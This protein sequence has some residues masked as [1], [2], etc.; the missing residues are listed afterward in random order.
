MF[1]QFEPWRKKRIGIVGYGISGQSAERLLQLLEYSSQPIPIWDEN[2]QLRRPS[3]GAN[4]D[5]PEQWLEKTGVDTL[6]VSPG[7]PLQTPWI[8]KILKSPSAGV[9]YEITSEIALASLFLATETVIAVTGSVGKST[10]TSLLAEAL[11][12]LGSP[13]FAGGNLGKPLSDY[14]GNLLERKESLAPRA[15]TLA[16]ELSS[17]QIENLGSFKAHYSLITALTPNHLDRYPSLESYYETKWG[18][19]QRTTRK[20]FLNSDSS[21]VQ[22]A[23]KLFG[24][25]KNLS[26]AWT[27]GKSPELEE[28]FKKKALVG[29]Y[30]NQNL[31]LALAICKEL[32]WGKDAEQRVLSFQGLP[33]RLE[34]VTAL[35]DPFQAVNDSKA[36]TLVSVLQALQSCLEIL[37]P[38]QTVH[39]LLGGRDKNLPWESLNSGNWPWSKIRIYYFGEVGP[40]AKLKINREGPVFGKLSLALDHLFSDPNESP[41]KSNDLILLSPGGAS[42][43]EFS[44][45][46]ER[47]NFFKSRLQRYLKSRLPVEL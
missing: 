42:Q 44:N 25:P 17:Y 16:L 21:E 11:S 34:R 3:S 12:S 7:Y 4:F 47:G 1:P 39:L 30:N 15:H 28:V 22:R 32:Q 18:L 33:H 26:V 10:V 41:I 24:V 43:D 23:E 2:S 45:F 37:P 14:M 27:S 20:V 5:T 38:N 40:R 8:Q 13:Y 35:T 29:S 6:I 9:S 19:L 36:T 31:A 46:E